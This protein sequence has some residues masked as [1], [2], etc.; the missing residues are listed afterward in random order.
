MNF[1]P[2]EHNLLLIFVFASM[3]LS[4]TITLSIIYCRKGRCDNQH[5]GRSGTKYKKYHHFLSI[6]Y[7]WYFTLLQQNCDAIWASLSSTTSKHWK[8][9]ILPSTSWG[10]PLARRNRAS[11]SSI[12][13][14][15]RNKILKVLHFFYWWYWKHKKK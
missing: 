15:L 12:W 7:S 14:I 6:N 8:Y 13:S 9:F 3:I 10:G 2:D 1:F 11:I 5:Q 4:V